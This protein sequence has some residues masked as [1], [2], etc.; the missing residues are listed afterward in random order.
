MKNTFAPQC[1]RSFMR[2]KALTKHVLDA[3]VNFTRYACDICERKYLDI[4]S[5]KRHFEKHNNP[6]GIP[7]D[8]CEKYYAGKGELQRHIKNNHT[9]TPTN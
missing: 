4:D 5:F 7:C 6:S 8:F 1:N 2:E 3:H 9:A